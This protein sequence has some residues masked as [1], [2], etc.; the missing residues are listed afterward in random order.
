MPAHAGARPDQH[1]GQHGAG[2]TARSR[3]RDPEGV[4]HRARNR[5][6]P[7]QG[8]RQEGG[9]RLGA[10]DVLPRSRLGALL[11]EAEQP[12]LHAP[13]AR[14]V[15]QGGEL[16][17][18]RVQL[19]VPRLQA[20]RLLPDRL[21]S[22]A[23]SR[24][25]TR[26]PNPR[27]RQIRLE[28]LQPEY[29][30]GG[31]AA[32][33]APP[34][35]RR[36]AI[37]R[38]VEQQAGARLGRRRRSVRLRPDPPAADDRRPRARRHQGW[39]EG[40]ARPARQ[41]DGG[42][43]DRGPARGKAAAPAGARDRQSAV[44]EAAERAVDVNGVAAGGRAPPRPQPGWG[45]RTQSSR[46]AHGRVVAAPRPRGVRADAGQAPLFTG[47]GMLPVGDHTRGTATAPDFFSGW[48]GYVSKDLRDL[49]GPK[50]RGAYS[51][52][53]CGGGS[54]AKCRAALRDSLRQALKV[55]PST[56]YGQNDDCSGDPDP[57]CYDQNR[58][59]I[60]SAIGIPPAPFQ[61]R[62]T[63]QQ[64]VSVKKNLP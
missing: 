64:T 26:L 42:A 2:D 44:G 7:G 19:V 14:L 34:A 62:P 18:L 9:L 46:G 29:A 52:V 47:P 31:L 50:P 6:R 53:Y 58:A 17:E 13:R 15:P 41:V 22:A 5:L 36:S 30:R 33:E 39:Q 28:G 59:V 55:R 1:V 56:L 27:N 4:P 24:H 20:H 63:F 51:S 35:R 25:V 3:Q 21:V 57:Q 60:T 32:P 45:L 11:H 23:G 38:L 37:S 49:F 12:K 61:N 43:G 40:I 10:L 48:W 8:P 16:H 54:K